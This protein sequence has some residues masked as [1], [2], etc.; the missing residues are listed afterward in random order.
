MTIFIRTSGGGGIALLVVLALL[1]G[2]GSGLNGTVAIILVVLVVLVVLAILGV[3]GM[4]ARRMRRPGGANVPSVPPATVRGEVLPGQ[5][6]QMLAGPE[7]RLPADQL[8]QLAELIRRQ[9][10]R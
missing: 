1:Y 8:E 7:V 5:P 6:R 3:L 9:A 10:E 2:H 4:L